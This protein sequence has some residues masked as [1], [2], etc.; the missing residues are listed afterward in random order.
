MVKEYGRKCSHCGHLGHNTRTCNNGN[1]N[2]VC[3]KLFGVNIMEK[4]DDNNFI[5]KSFSM[6]NLTNACDIEHKNITSLGIDD[7]G[8]LSDGV[9]HNGKHKASQEK[10]RGTYRP[11]FFLFIFL[12]S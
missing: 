4:R 2:G 6:G 10:K 5:K 9:I 8:Y 1:D 12:I 3:L 11:V 7:F